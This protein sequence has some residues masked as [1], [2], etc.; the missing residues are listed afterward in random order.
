MTNLIELTQHREPGQKKPRVSFTKEEL[1]AILDVYSRHVAQGEWKDYAIDINGP[2]A[3]FS[4]FRHSFD[5]PLFSFGKRRNGR[6][7]EYM[8]LDKGRTVKRSTSLK[9]ILKLVD[10][11]MKLIRLPD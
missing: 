3:T 9:A 5:S 10:K 2:V 4:V 11:P 7:I 6:A 1:R 8:L